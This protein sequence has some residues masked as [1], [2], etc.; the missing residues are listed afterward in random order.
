M[1][2]R[3]ILVIQLALL[4]LGIVAWGAINSDLKE[5][6]KLAKRSNFL[7]LQGSPFGRTI[8]LAMRG[9]VDVYWHRGAIH[10]DDHDH[11]HEHH[12]EPATISTKDLVIDLDPHDH[13]HGDHH[14]HDHHGHDHGDHHAHDHGTETNA[15][16]PPSKPEGPR[17]YL[18]DKIKTMRTAYYSR[19]NTR[20]ESPRHRAFVMGET[21]KKLALSYH[22]DPTNNACYGAYFMFLSEAVARVEGEKDEDG[23]IRA[24]QLKALELARYTAYY[25][26]NYQDEAPAMITAA[27]A[28]HDYLQIYLKLPKPDPRVATEFLTI[29]NGSLQRYTAIRAEMIRAGTWEKFPSARRK[30]MEDAFRLLSLFRE[31]DLKAVNELTSTAAVTP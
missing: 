20:M 17:L 24:R 12:G 28:A 29:L 25:C 27:N 18:L 26:L 30:E 14:G 10:L 6:G 5:Q 19:T 7:H 2:K 11:D 4:A 23:T 8:A 1:K 3:T 15:Q 9:P 13:G 21:Q 22:M 16:E 31:T